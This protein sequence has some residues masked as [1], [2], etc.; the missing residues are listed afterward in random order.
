MQIPTDVAITGNRFLLLSWFGDYRS[1]RFLCGTSV[2][3][4]FYF[5]F[6]R[7]AKEMNEAK[8]QRNISIIVTERC[9]LSCVYCYEHNK[10]AKQMTF[11]IAKKIIDE[12]LT[13]LDKYEYMIDFFGGE[14]FFEFQV[15]KT[16]CRIHF[17]KLFGILSFLCDNERYTYSRGNTKV[18]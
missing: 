12:E 18:A 8:K 2:A 1:L 13:N 9:N 3:A 17:I 5:T 4:L 7:E 16:S 11:E 14:P 15:N 10:S 6:F